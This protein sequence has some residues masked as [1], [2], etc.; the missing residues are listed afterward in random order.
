MFGCRMPYS[1]LR[2]WRYHHNGTIVRED[3]RRRFRSGKEASP[4]VFKGGEDG[5]DMQ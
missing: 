2:F 1:G 4:V 3:A 5:T